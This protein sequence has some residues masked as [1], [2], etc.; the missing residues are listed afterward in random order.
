MTW[1]K[2][3]P[4]RWQATHPTI[5]AVVTKKTQSPVHT[6]QVTAATKSHLGTGAICISGTCATLLH[7]KQAADK[8]AARIEHALKVITGWEEEA[9]THG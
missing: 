8:A 7:A 3:T 6:W 1:K 5:N 9:D 4:V 2:L